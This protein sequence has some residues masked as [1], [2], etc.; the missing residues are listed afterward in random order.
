M[1]S[2]FSVILCLLIAGT[3]MFQQLMAEPTPPGMQPTYT[4]ENGGFTYY[5]ING[6]PLP[7][8][9]KIFLG[10][11]SRGGLIYDDEGNATNQ[12]A[13]DTPENARYWREERGQN[14]SSG[15][16]FG[17]SE[18]GQDWTNM[19]PGGDQV[20]TVAG[21]SINISQSI[22]SFCLINP[23][24]AK[25]KDQ[26]QADLNLDVQVLTAE[27]KSGK[28]SCDYDPKTAEAFSLSSGND[29]LST[30]S[31]QATILENPD[32][33]VP[34]GDPANS[35][36]SSMYVAVEATN[37]AS[38]AS[39]E[40]QHLNQNS[41]FKQRCQE[42]AK[43]SQANAADLQLY[44]YPC[45]IYNIMLRL[46]NLFADSDSLYQHGVELQ[47]VLN[48]AAA[49]NMKRDNQIK[50]EKAKLKELS[51][52]IKK[53]IRE[54]DK[55]KKDQK[56]AQEE[57][58][59]AQEALEAANKIEC[60]KDAE[61]KEDCSARDA[62]I[63]AAQSKLKESEK[64]LKDAEEKL[65]KAVKVM[66]DLLVNKMGAETSAVLALLSGTIRGE[67]GD[68]DVQFKVA[69]NDFTL[70][71]MGKTI[72]DHL[73]VDSNSAKNFVD[74]ENVSKGTTDFFTALVENYES[75]VDEEKGT[76]TAKKPTAK[77][78]GE[79]LNEIASQSGG[80]E[81]LET[82]ALAIADY[83]EQATE[84]LVSHLESM[85][86]PQGRVQ[87]VL[88]KL[89]ESRNLNLKIQA[90]ISRNICYLN[91]VL[92][93]YREFY[94]LSKNTIT[95]NATFFNYVNEFTSKPFDQKLK[96]GYT[97]KVD[98]AAVIKTYECYADSG[99][100]FTCNQQAGN[101]GSKDSNNQKPLECKWQ[102]QGFVAGPVTPPQPFCQYPNSTVR[103][104]NI[105][106]KC[107][108]TGKE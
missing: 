35:Q 69:G 18:G 19:G 6:D 47:A 8:G 50:N 1:K 81:N 90:M 52:K 14:M 51:N 33:I 68:N 106:W 34:V 100:S 83:K 76:A 107:V 102:A 32:A 61:D 94:K 59:K 63:A 105:D 43:N 46:Q 91:V 24:D 70:I 9:T 88:A 13:Y 29:R 87:T 28:A 15:A 79:I 99:T 60:V 12:M 53:A 65:K 36:S 7:P 77:V 42:I 10:L 84:K 85:K 80:L 95:N 48:Q 74:G 2:K 104:E 58:K 56:K 73:G 37:A 3:L 78:S 54:L 20:K 62:A 86:T 4:N 40:A 41:S 44:A 30:L 57:V 5:D 22:K 23:Q 39:N 103:R 98:I 108:C 38:M 31:S 72:S 25:C 21:E 67:A 71:D 27:K 55:A 17:P 26:A 11:D 82:M 101:K 97:S 96:E 16:V 75:S 93:S 49:E 45:M 89:E 64:K 66:V 92:N